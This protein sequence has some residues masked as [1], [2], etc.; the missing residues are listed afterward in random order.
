MKQVERTYGV[1]LSKPAWMW[2]CEMGAND[3]GVVIG[4]GIVLTKVESEEKKSLLGTDL[5][6]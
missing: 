3:Q 4:N 6:R 5:T 2:G 1:I